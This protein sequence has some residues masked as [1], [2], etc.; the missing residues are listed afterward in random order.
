MVSE[1]LQINHKSKSYVVPT[2]CSTKNYRMPC[3]LGSTLVA[4]I[5]VI[6]HPDIPQYMVSTDLRTSDNSHLGFLFCCSSPSSASS[7]GL[8]RYLALG[9]SI[10]CYTQGVRSA[11]L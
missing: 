5:D 9:V 10:R 6:M 4:N 11:M 3:G 1:V 8:I 7:K 2:G